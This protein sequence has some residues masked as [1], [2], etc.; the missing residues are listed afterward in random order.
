VLAR[1][2]LGSDIGSDENPSLT[3]QDLAPPHIG[4]MFDH[5]P[6]DR[7]YRDRPGLMVFELQPPPFFIMLSAD[8]YGLI[9]FDPT[10]QLVPLAETRNAGVWTDE[11]RLAYDLV[12][13]SLTLPNPAAKYILVVTAI[14]ALIPYQA[15]SEELSQLLDSL[16][17][18]VDQAWSYDEDTRESVKKLL[19]S[20]K[21]QSVRQHAIKL[22]GRLTGEYDGK[23]PKKFFDD[24]Y[25]VRSAL[26]HGNPRDTPRL[27]MDALNKQYPQVLEF[28][29]DVLEAWTPDGSIA[30]SDPGDAGLT[31]SSA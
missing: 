16:R 11:L 20:A 13:G 6:S 28:V 18:T 29:L 22:V 12:H 19:D 24:I 17:P 2:G 26:A 7:V 31:G 30:A 14:E 3:T 15:R 5:G 27:S 8:A 23:T 25:G 21:M 4:G 10:G 9:P 1:L